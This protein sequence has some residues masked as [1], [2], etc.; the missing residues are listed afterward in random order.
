MHVSSGRPMLMQ[1]RPEKNIFPAKIKKKI[2]ILA[3]DYYTEL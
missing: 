3:K 1:F 2:R